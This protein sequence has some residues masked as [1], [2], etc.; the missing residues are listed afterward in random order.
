MSKAHLAS[1]KALSQAED[2][3]RE[4]GQQCLD[5]GEGLQ[6]V[7]SQQWGELH[8]SRAQGLAPSCQGLPLQPLAQGLSPDKASWG[9]LLTLPSKGD[10]WQVWP[11]AGCISH[12][13]PESNSVLGA[14]PAQHVEHPHGHG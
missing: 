2:R 7:A 10:G 12:C 5:Q 4:G 11:L 14:N 3:G 9:Y 6:P 13:S 1:G 8:C